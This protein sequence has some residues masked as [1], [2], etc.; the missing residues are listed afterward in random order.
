MNNNTELEVQIREAL[1]T[2]EPASSIATQ[3]GLDYEEYEDAVLLP[4]YVAM[5]VAEG[6]EAYYAEAKSADEAA[7]EY[8]DDSYY[9]EDDGTTRWV[10]VAAWRTGFR[11]DGTG[12]LEERCKEERSRHTLEPEIP[13]CVKGVDDHNWTAVSARVNGAGHVHEDKC[14]FCRAR[15][16]TNTWAQD[17]WDGRQGLTSTTY[18]LDED[19]RTEVD[20]SEVNDWETINTYVAT[21]FDNNE[22]GEGA[23][24]VE[25]QIG[26]ADGGLW[27]IRTRDD[28]GGYD[29]APD[30]AFTSR[31]AGEAAAT[32]FTALQHDAAPGE[33]AEDYLHRRRTESAELDPEG[34]W[35][36]Y[37]ET[38]LDDE[39]VV[40]RH[41]TQM[42]AEAA[43]FIHEQKLVASNP[44][45]LR[46][47]YSV[48]KLVDGEWID[49]EDLKD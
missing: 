36:V 48:R 19:F 13:C 30:D 8:M 35:A 34:E 16:T 9:G 37:W 22:I 49:T 17:P 31:E 29:N 15:R 10:T 25:V 46:C 26:E 47:G 38:A 40:S 5:D 11:F 43:A 28:A 44:G 27:F 32:S 20:K 23:C 12:V 14:S 4:G 24:D 42:A 18:Y 39:H 2:G 3:L 6:E 1:L 7:S 45:V 33:N 21:F 41:P